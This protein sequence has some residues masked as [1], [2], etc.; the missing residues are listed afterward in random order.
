MSWRDHLPVHPAAE[1]FPLMKDT[2]PE[3]LRKLADDIE[4]NGLREFVDIYDDPELGLCVLDGRNRLDAL[5]LMG[6]EKDGNERHSYELPSADSRKSFIGLGRMMSEGSNFDPYAYVVSKNLHRRHLTPEQKRELIAKVL[7]A[8]PEQSNRQVA[9]QVKVDHKTVGAERKRLEA[10]GE[11]PQ[12][13]KTVGADGKRRPKPERRRNESATAN[14][15]SFS[16]IFDAE[17]EGEDPVGFVVAVVK[18]ATEKAQ[19]AVRNLPHHLTEGEKAKIV[20]AIDAMSRKWNAVRRK[21]EL[22]AA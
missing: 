9:E 14:A 19:S 12:L 20:D 5:E 15:E 10:T 6:W 3:G 2:D 8:K 4:N 1:L 18:N 21:V 7:K 16:E 22:K 13:K 17:D 11:I